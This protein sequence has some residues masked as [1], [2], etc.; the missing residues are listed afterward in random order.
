MFSDLELDE[1]NLSY[2]VSPLWRGRD[3]GHEA[4]PLA[5]DH[6][7]ALPGRL[8]PTLKIAPADTASVRVANKAGFDGHA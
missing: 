3:L 1:A 8:H 4:L 2:A 6:L 7:D 5:L